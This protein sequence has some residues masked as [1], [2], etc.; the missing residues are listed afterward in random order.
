MSA[1]PALF[2]ALD[3][4]RLMGGSNLPSLTSRGISG[5]RDLMRQAKFIRSSTFQWTLAVV[6]VLAVFVIALFGFIY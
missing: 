1:A 2:F 3:H 6:G 5:R 4:K